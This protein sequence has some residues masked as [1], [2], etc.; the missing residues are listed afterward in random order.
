MIFL[1]DL[2][3]LKK[4]HPQIAPDVNSMLVRSLSPTQ[5]RIY[6]LLGERTCLT[7]RELAIQYGMIQTS[8]AQAMREMRDM[9][10][11]DGKSM[12]VKGAPN[13]LIYWRVA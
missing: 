8:A 6:D 12:P 4:K 9:G 2:I 5:R 10:I 13:K 1:N 3:N 11:V 7:S